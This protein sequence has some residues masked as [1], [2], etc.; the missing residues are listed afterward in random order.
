MIPASDN[1]ILFFQGYAI[2]VSFLLFIAAGFWAFS[3]FNMPTWLG[4]LIISANFAVMASFTP[5]VNPIVDSF[6][7]GIS[8]ITIRLYFKSHEV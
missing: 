2:A 4:Y 7:L 1:V 5:H 6:A 3:I 8:L